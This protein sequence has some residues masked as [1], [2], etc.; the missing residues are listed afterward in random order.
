MALLDEE[1]GPPMVPPKGI[2]SSSETLPTMGLGADMGEQM[3]PDGDH[4]DA[5][6][7]HAQTMMEAIKAGDSESLRDSMAAFV[8]EC[9]RNYEKGKK[10][11]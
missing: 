1:D 9:V 6:S 2:L 4:S 7:V 8:R 3:A 11:E 10:G 5:E